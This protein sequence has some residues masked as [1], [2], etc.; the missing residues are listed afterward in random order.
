MRRAG[1]PLIPR[2][3]TGAGADNRGNTGYVPDMDDPLSRYV[4]A[5]EQLDRT[6]L[7]G[8]LE[9][10]DPDMHFRDPFNDCHGVAAFGRVMQH[11]FETLDEVRFASHYRAITTDDPSSALIHWTLDAKFGRFNGRP[12]HVEGCSM[13]RFSADGKLTAHYDYWDAASGFYERLPILG[14]L[15]RSLRRR[16]AVD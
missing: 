15:L 4:N 6:K 11:M 16:I 5:L 8:L 3:E 1:P 2:A 14:R 10:C 7:A 9:M 12:W 13:L